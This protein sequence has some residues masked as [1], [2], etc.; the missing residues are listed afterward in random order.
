MLHR[1]IAATTPIQW[2]SANDPDGPVHFFAPG[3]LETRLDQFTQG[4]PGLVTYAVKSNPAPAVIS[5]LWAG[6]IGGFDVASPTEIALINRLC[7]GAA[8]HY[9]N[10]VRSPREIRAGIDGGVV[11]WSVDTGGELAKLIAAGVPRGNEIAV[12]FRLPVKGAVYDFGA[13]FG[14]EPAD[15]V[16][17]LQ[18]VLQ[19]GYRPAL[20]FHAGTQC[21]DPAAFQ[22]YVETAA[23]I[24]QDAGVPIA[25]LNVGGGFPAGRDGG[26]PP[27]APIF[28]AIRAGLA[29]FAA[30][31]ALV[32]E[33]GRALVSDAF[34]YA[35]RVKSIRPARVYLEDGIY[36]GLSEFV[37][38][39]QPRLTVLGPNGPRTGAPVQRTI[40]G[41]TCDSLDKLP[42][43][44][45]LPADLAEGD[46]L[47]WQSMGAYVTGVSTTFNGYGAWE[48]VTVER[49]I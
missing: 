26:D 42:G 7:P 24:A 46:W 30:P 21:T 2:L 38:I 15:A 12:R 40:F 49:L 29:A 4:F 34:A 44:P 41:P 28:A 11:S 6:G 35:V 20:T 1:P 3:A 13:K 8:L 47:I 39:D 27:L 19:A 33:P 9:N 25:R 18:D 14:A 10:P 48:T 43:T 31:P 37:Y 17:L 45:G 22:T 36:G 23:R 32:C 5:A 16:A